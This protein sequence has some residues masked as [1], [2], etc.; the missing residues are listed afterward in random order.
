[1]VSMEQW[2]LLAVAVL[3]SF[4]ALYMIMRLWQ[5]A[6]WGSPPPVR[7]EGGP[8]TGPARLG[9][10]FGILT[11]APIAVLVGCSLLMGV[12]G[13]SAWSVAHQAAATL[14]DVDTYIDSVALAEHL[15]DSG[16]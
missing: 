5:G 6:F 11:L 12:F 15:S 3:S 13:E 7:Y 10:G 8:T 14:T 9:P 16:H 4:V 1:M 2:L